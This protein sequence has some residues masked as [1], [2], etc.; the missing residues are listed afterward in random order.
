MNKVTNYSESALVD[1]SYY[2]IQ[3]GPFLT[4]AFY[5]NDTWFIPNYNPIQSDKIK[6]ELII[7]ELLTNQSKITFAK[8]SVIPDKDLIDSSYYIIIYGL[9]LTIGY[10]SNGLWYIPGHSNISPKDCIDNITVIQY[11]SDQSSL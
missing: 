7:I 5:Y 8:N 4:I 3:Y 2:S 1:N 11:F 10:Y 6:D 9:I